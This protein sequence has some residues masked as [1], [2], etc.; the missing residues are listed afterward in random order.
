MLHRDVGRR[1]TMPDGG[2]DMPGAKRSE[3]DSAR[4]AAH[5]KE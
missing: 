1:R 5:L 3:P 4:R 2:P